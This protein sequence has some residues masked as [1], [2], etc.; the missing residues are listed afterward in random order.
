MKQHSTKALLK[1]GGAGAVALAIAVVLGASVHSQAVPTAEY[2]MVASPDVAADFASRHSLAI[3]ERVEGQRDV[4]LLTGIVEE[5][6]AAEIEADA[7]TDSHIASFERNRGLKV[8]EVADAKL[9][10][11]S[12]AILETLPDKTPVPYYGATAWKGYVEQPAAK[13]IKVKDAQGQYGTGG[14]VVV[15]VID[16]GIDAK[17]PLLKGLVRDGYDFVRQVPGG[18]G[19]TSDLSGSSAAILETG[20]GDLQSKLLNGSVAAIL[21]G[22]VAAILEGSSAAILEGSS[23]AILENGGGLGKGFGHGTMVAGLI[24]LVAPT[25]ELMPVTAFDANGDSDIFNIVRSIYYAADHGARVINMSFSMP[26]DSRAI[27]RALRYAADKGVITVAAAG[28]ASSGVNVFPASYSQTTGVASTSDLDSRS[29]FSNYGSSIVTL[30]APGEKLITTYPG[31]HYAAAWGTSFSSG[32]VSGTA[33]ML[34]QWVPSMKQGDFENALATGAKKIGQDV[35]QGRLDI[36][37]TLQKKV[38]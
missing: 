13:I 28:N 19:D 29:K 9:G 21:E 25:A 34:L 32:F 20:T 2:I 5:T 7:A 35:G 31:A 33:A 3:E 26:Q 18:V 12:A 24:H 11:S 38:K 37:T 36:Y 23:A 15:A 1:S 27:A 10:G 30:A 8:T 14:N 6:E 17:H 16:T 22:S 4:A